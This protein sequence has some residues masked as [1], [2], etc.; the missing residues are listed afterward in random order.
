M[1]RDS[2]NLDD[3]NTWGGLL[4]NDDD[5]ERKI[6]IG[7]ARFQTRTECSDVRFIGK[8]EYDESSGYSHV[9]DLP[10]LF[11]DSDFESNFEEL[12]SDNPPSELLYNYMD[13]IAEYVVT[14]ERVNRVR[15]VEIKQIYWP[16]VGGVPHTLQDPDDSI[17]LFG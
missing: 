2:R 8:G 9:E 11:S 12:C 10:D 4:I 1:G 17:V 7:S 5:A 3:V 13:F 14:K 15:E 16:D 6:A